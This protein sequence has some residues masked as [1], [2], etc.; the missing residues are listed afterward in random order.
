MGSG[1]LEGEGTLSP[2]PEGIPALPPIIASLAASPTRVQRIEVG[3]FPTILPF[4][5]LP[6]SLGAFLAAGSCA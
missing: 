4:S 3:C 6:V 2:D 5:C 1:R